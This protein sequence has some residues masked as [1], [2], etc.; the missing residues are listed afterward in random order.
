M[1]DEEE[2][3]RDTHATVFKPELFATKLRATAGAESV[4]EMRV[5][6]TRNTCGERY[7]LPGSKYDDREGRK[8]GK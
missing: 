1:V 6:R 3:G 4:F 2:A 5:L 7:C 8:L